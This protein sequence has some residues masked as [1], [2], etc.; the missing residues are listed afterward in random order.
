MAVLLGKKIEC[1]NKCDKC[2]MDY[3]NKEVINEQ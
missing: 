3:L 2:L 1:N